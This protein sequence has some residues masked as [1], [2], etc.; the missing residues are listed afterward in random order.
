MRRATTEKLK[1]NR[2]RKVAV[3]NVK[4]SMDTMPPMI[5]GKLR[6]VWDPLCHMGTW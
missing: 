3:G 4:K 5:V 2:I 1:T 6:Q